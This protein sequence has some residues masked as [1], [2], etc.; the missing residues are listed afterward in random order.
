MKLIEKF[1]KEFYSTNPSADPLK[2]LEESIVKVTQQ[3]KSNLSEKLFFY[4]FIIL[5]KNKTKWFFLDTIL[6]RGGELEIL[7]NSIQ[8]L[9]ETGALIHSKSVALNRKLWW[10]NFKVWIV[11]FFVIAVVVAVV[12]IVLFVAF[13]HAF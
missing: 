7:E 3:T 11:L 6:E 12:L 4:Y 8:D 1:E 5:K 2:Q 10:Q 13:R 9:A